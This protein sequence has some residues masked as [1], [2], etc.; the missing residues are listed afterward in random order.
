MTPYSS[1]SSVNVSVVLE[2]QFSFYFSSFFKICSK[3]VM[4]SGFGDTGESSLC[5][6]VLGTALPAAL[7]GTARISVWLFG[8]LLL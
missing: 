4:I 1:L 2:Y 8:N 5:E 3:N 6:I 7:L